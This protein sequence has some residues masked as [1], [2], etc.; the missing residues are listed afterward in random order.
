MIQGYYLDGKDSYTIIAD[1]DNT[2]NQKKVKG[3]KRYA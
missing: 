1:P 3:I 2:L